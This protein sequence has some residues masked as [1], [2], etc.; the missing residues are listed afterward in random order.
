MWDTDKGVFRGKFMVLNILHSK[1]RETS[2][3]VQWVR[4]YAPNAGG[5]VRSLVRELVPACMP[6]LRSPCVA[7]KT[8]RSQ[9][10]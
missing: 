1:R 8:W 9:N 10:K 3:V 2:L 5:L 4:L 7:T 6:Q